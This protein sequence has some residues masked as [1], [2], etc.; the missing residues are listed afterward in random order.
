MRVLK[1]GLCVPQNADDE[2]F[3]RTVTSIRNSVRQLVR[4]A[5]K[6]IHF[7]AG[8]VMAFDPLCG[9]E[10][11]PFDGQTVDSERV[12]CPV[13]LADLKGDRRRPI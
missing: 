5:P 11:G 8:N 4:I 12:T 9:C 1:D 10:E 2:Q 3:L 7:W 6:R 13:C